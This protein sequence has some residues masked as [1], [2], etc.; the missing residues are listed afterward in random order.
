M[1]LDQI[2][3]LGRKKQDKEKQ[4]KKASFVYVNVSV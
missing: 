2:P 1:T 4:K 3:V